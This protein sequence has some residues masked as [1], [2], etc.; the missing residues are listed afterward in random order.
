MVIAPIYRSKLCRLLIPAGCSCVN[1]M[2]VRRKG[3]LFCDML[4]SLMDNLPSQ[5][6]L[7]PEDLRTVFQGLKSEGKKKESYG[8]LRSPFPLTFYLS[9]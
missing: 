7:D 2:L 1:L 6:V 8:V 3:R 4:C 9:H 5:E